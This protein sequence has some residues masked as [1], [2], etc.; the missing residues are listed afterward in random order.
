MRRVFDPLFVTLLCLI[1]IAVHG[2]SVRIL[3]DATKAEMAGN[4]DWVIDADLANLR[5][6]P[7]A[8]T[9]SSGHQSNPQRYPTPDQSTITAT[10]DETYWEGALSSWAIDLVK[11]GY[12]V[13]TLPYNGAI[14]YGNTSNAQDLSNYKVFIIDEP[15]IRFSAAEQSAIVSFVQHGGGLFMISDHNNSDRNGDGWDSPHIWDDLLANN[16]IQSYPFGIYFD[17][18]DF[19]QTCTNVVSGVI[20]P[21]I[22]GPIGA[23]T[24]VKWSDG[25]SMTLNPSLNSTV[26]GVIFKNGTTAGNTN[27]MFAYSKFGSGKVAAMGDSSPPDDGTG[28][29]DCSL[30]SSYRDEVGGNHRRLLMNATIWLA[31]DDTVATAVSSITSETDMF[32]LFPD[33]T[34]DKASLLAR[35]DADNVSV[36]AI[37]ESGSVVL[38]RSYKNL[39]NGDNIPLILSKGCYFVKVQCNGY[40]HTFKLIVTN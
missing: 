10:T 16:S 19:S 6:G 26:K 31:T 13:E 33:P 14:S 28:N 12:G 27:A 21:V 1:S 8:Y 20:D 9:S 35:H 30:Y 37:T 3:F 5:Y 29:P 34:T 23:V 38:E 36:Q 32:V 39:R 25:T 2:Q 24:S 18:V 11:Q 22:H 7:N 15:N 4:A 17:T 40:L